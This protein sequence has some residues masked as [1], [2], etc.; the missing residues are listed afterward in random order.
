MLRPHSDPV[1]PAR[2]AIRLDG[3]ARR[4]GQ[5]WVLRGIDLAVEAGEVLAVTGR[6]GSGKTTL[7]RIV[8]T[9]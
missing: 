3:V 5:R 4:L 9:L 1:T 6:N 8:G 7:L 2:A